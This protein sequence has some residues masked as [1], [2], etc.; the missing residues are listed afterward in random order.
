MKGTIEF[1][2][3]I[4]VFALMAL[5]GTGYITASINTANARDYHASIINELEASNFNQE[6]IESLYMDATSKGYILEPIL[7]YEI[8]G[9]QKTAEVI[10]NYNYDIGVLNITGEQHIIR[11]Y[12]R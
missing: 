2:L 11:G 4:I 10:L 7:P 1:F 3:A 12:A 9:H 8:E 5:T 6:V